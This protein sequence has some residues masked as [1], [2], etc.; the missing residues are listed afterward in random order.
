MR[1]ACF[2]SCERAARQENVDHLDSRSRVLFAYGASV[3]VASE[4]L[5]YNANPYTHNHVSAP[6]R[7]PLPAEPHVEAWERYAA[8]A[9]HSGLW[10]VLQKRFPQLNFPI[11]QGLS[12]HAEYQ[13]ATRRGTPT[14]T[15]VL[16][17]GLELDDADGLQL[18]LHPTLAGVIPVLVAAN[19]PDFVSL[20]QALTRR[21]EPEPLPASM[22]A[23]IVSGYN[24]WDRITELRRRWQGEKS[25]N[26]SLPDWAEEF[27]QNILPFPALYQDTFILLSQGPYSNVPAQHMGMSVET[28]RQTSLTLR[29][30]HE[31]A[32]YFTYRLFGSMRNNLLDEL[33][34]DYCGIVAA[35]GHYRADW[36]LRFMGLESF[37]H[38]REGGRLENYRGD[39]PLS[40]EAFHILGH[41]VKDAAENLERLDQDRAAELQTSEGKA[42]L[43]LSLARLTLEEIAAKENM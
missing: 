36:F 14:N 6:P 39:P 24:N 30:E 32:H 41:L 2:A 27:R 22:G 19:R 18:R 21:N 31:C 4:L 17:S 20:A 40:E 11:R 43:L 23:C 37:P 34:A 25:A 28:W 3:T 29:L 42:R 8:E 12:Q 15:L 10:P 7:F 1:R 26:P 33:I 16:A 13:A 9:R 38:Y 5:D 35:N